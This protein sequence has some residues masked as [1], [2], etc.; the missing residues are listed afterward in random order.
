M[1][2]I[3]SHC[4][5]GLM[6]SGR[7]GGKPLCEDLVA[8]QGVESTVKKITDHRLQDIRR[9]LAG[10]GDPWGRARRFLQ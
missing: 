9:R 4:R 3:F 2:G 6:L 8:S 1:R 7:E 10:L 5:L